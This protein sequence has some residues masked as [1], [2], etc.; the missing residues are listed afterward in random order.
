MS[1]TTRRLGR[2]AA[3]SGLLLALVACSG[4]ASSVNVDDVPAAERI[5]VSIGYN[6]NSSWDPLNT[7][8]AFAMAAQNHIYE[9]L[10]DAEAVTR[11]PYAALAAA[12][13]TDDELTSKT[14]TVKLRDGAKWQDGQPVTADDVV[15]SFGRVLDPA[16]KI[17]T[18]GFFSD[19]LDSVN[20][21]D[22]QTV[23]INMKFPFTYALQRFSIVKIMPKHVFEGKDASFLAQGKNALGSGPYKVAAHEDT[24]FTRLVLADTYNG[25]L[26]PTVKQ[27]QWN[28]AVDPAARLASLTAAS[29]PV[30][31]SDNIP[32]DGLDQLKQRGLTV[33]GKDSMNM[34]GLAFNT[35]KAPF[36]N[37]LVR[38]ALRTAIDTEKLIDVSISG[39]GTPATS[40]L[41]ESSPYYNKANTQY[42]YNQEKAKALLKQAGV[43]TPIKIRLMST[44]I[45]WTKVAVNTIKESWDAIG[46][47]TTLDVVETAQFN[48]KLAAGD[49]A[50]VVTF[51]GNPNQFGIDPDLNVR[52]FYSPTSQFMP[53]NKWSDTSDYKALMEQLDA[54]LRATSESEATKKM[55]IALDTIA[56]EAVVYPVMH[57]KLFTAWD[58]NKIGG[59][60]ALDIPGVNLL[61]ATRKA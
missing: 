19:W 3:V 44:N 22:D 1:A 46:V 7:G 25:P 10:W 35:S 16:S 37:K 6:N 39:Q 34:L 43:S 51:S 54:A 56:D 17:I 52:W 24:S 12:L 53:W 5:E 28:V 20:K 33:E 42:T 60:Q 15:F 36:D 21:V 49:D 47:E 59:V 61:N 18:T 23:Q 57:M 38:Q 55:N 40:F 11:K 45:S 9:A 8:S 13:P 2:G 41:Q 58:A 48:S 4:P 32:T 50:D 30:Q 31:I 26:K 29:D 14:W 27:L